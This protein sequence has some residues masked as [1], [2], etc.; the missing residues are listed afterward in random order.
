MSFTAGPFTPAANTPI[1]VKN[2]SAGS[3]SLISF[4][5]V[6]VNISGFELIV[7]TGVGAITGLVDPFTRDIVYLSAEAGQ[8][9]TIDPVDL[10]FTGPAGISPRIYVIFYLSNEPVPQ[11]LP[12]PIVPYGN[13]QQVTIVGQPDLLSVEVFASANG[14]LLPQ[15]GGTTRYR[16]FAILIS[17]APS[18]G[19]YYTI[20]DG[21]DGS[22]LSAILGA[23]GSSPSTS[24]SFAPKGRPLVANAAVYGSYPFGGPQGLA[25]VIAYS[26]EAA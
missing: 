20:V 1:T 13:L 26:V 18:A 12:A 6:I 23:T 3:G 25:A 17:S 5:A 4:A 16:I 14:N 9:L 21:T 10:G 11:A 7:G 15:P 2:P 19:L 24:I 8:Q 22:G